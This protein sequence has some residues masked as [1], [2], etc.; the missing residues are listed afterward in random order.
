MKKPIKPKKPI[1]NINPPEELGFNRL[2]VMRK[3]E[4]IHLLNESDHFYDEETCEWSYEKNDLENLG[5]TINFK[6]LLKVKELLGTDDFDVRNEFDSDGYY[7]LTS[8]SYKSKK[9]DIQYQLELNAFN[10]RFEIYETELKNYELELE[11]YSKYCK[12]CK[13]EKLKKELQKL[14]SAQNS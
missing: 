7:Y 6:D 1:K 12:E 5:E 9:S 11:K 3:G 13:M 2:I 8:I 14:E 4:D 10:M